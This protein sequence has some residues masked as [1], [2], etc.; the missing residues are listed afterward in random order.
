MQLTGAETWLVREMIAVV[1][2]AALGLFSIT[3][4]V[5]YN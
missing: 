3:M 2:A 4:I 5:E 1:P